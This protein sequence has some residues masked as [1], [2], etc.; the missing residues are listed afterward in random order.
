MT[1]IDY[2]KVIDI[3]SDIF[4]ASRQVELKAKGGTVQTF[5]VETVMADKS[6]LQYKMTLKK[7][8]V[9]ILINKKYF[10]YLKKETF[11]SK[12]E[13]MLEQVFF[14]NIKLSLIDEGEEYYITI[15]V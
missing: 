4:K 13:Y 9:S 12:M 2:M 15:S 6:L 10:E 14:K 8:D 11:F 3:I 5:E 7:Y 1:T